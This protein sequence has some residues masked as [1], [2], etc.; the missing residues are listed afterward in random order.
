MNVITN[1]RSQKWLHKAIYTIMRQFW[2]QE[3]WLAKTPWKRMWKTHKG[4]KT[5]FTSIQKQLKKRIVFWTSYLF[6]LLFQDD[7]AEFDSFSNGFQ[8][9]YPSIIRLLWSGVQLCMTKRLLFLLQINNW[10]P[11]VSLS[12]KSEQI[13]KEKWTE[14]EEHCSFQWMGP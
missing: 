11:V 6:N 3:M 4:R 13:L 7:K 5:G 14:F 1:V 9:L 12:L 2:S 10:I 8:S